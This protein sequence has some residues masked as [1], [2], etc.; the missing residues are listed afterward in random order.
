M[1]TQKTYRLFL[2]TDILPSDFSTAQ[3]VTDAL[4]TIALAVKTVQDKL[5]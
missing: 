2:R 3:E 5:F 4:D 1:L